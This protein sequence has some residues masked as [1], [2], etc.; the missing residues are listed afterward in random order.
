MAIIT[1]VEDLFLVVLGCLVPS[2][3]LVVVGTWLIESQKMTLRL[4]PPFSLTKTS[5][6]ALTTPFTSAFHLKIWGSSWWFSIWFWS[7]LFR[8]IT[9]FSLWRTLWTSIDSPLRNFWFMLHP[10]AHAIKKKQRNNFF[11]LLNSSWHPCFKSWELSQVYL[12]AQTRSKPY[13]LGHIAFYQNMIN[14]HL[15]STSHWTWRVVHNVLDPQLFSDLENIKSH[16]PHKS[17]TLWFCFRSPYKL[18]SS[19]TSCTNWCHLSLVHYGSCDV[20]FWLNI[21]HSLNAFK[22]E[23]HFLDIFEH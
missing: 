8:G 7:F 9:S 16:P 11:F 18:P 6:L 2:I 1:D 17:F 22:L 20:Q 4:D 3:T 5:K 21:H 14:K 15:A 12:Q 19:V 10:M 13:L 23:C